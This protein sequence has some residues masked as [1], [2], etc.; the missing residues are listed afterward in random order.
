[1]PDRVTVAAEG[2]PDA[3]RSAREE[4][5]SLLGIDTQATDLVLDLEFTANRSGEALRSL[6]D[7]SLWYLG[8]KI[9]K[10]D[11]KSAELSKPI[12]V[13]KPVATQSSENAA[14]PH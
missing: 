10:L 12:E 14:Q 11:M 6:E 7:L 9:A 8:V 5:V 4:T 13:A 1:M 3:Q 2:A